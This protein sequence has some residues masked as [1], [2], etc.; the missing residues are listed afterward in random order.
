[1][2]KDKDL[3][4][5]MLE[6]PNLTLEDM[7]SV[8]HSAE[9]TRF[10]DKS[11]YENSQKVR[12]KFTDAEGNFKQ[13]EFNTWYDTAAKAYQ[14][15]TSKD[16]NIS[17]LNVAAFDESD[18]TVSPEKRTLNTK[19]IVSF[20]PNPDRL[21][22]SIY[23]VGKTSERERTQSELAQAEKILLNPVEA[24]A[25]PSKAKWGD[26]PNDSWWSN[27]FD[28]Q[29]LAQW[30]EDGT[31][32]D[33]VTGQ[34]VQHQKGELKLNDN[35]TYYYE[36]LDGR[37][38][39]GRQVL[40]K[41]NTITTDGSFW[42]QY[43]FFD[44]DDI[45][46]KSFVGSVA[47]NLA[48]VGSMFIPYV[49]WGVAGASVA[50]QL[51]GLTGTL[52][53][54][55]T[56]SDSPTF[57]AMEGW[58]KSLNRQTA[59]SEY[60]QQN[61]LCW[62]NF[63][64]LI[65]DTTAQL[66]EQRAIFKFAPAILG[67]GKYGI[68]SKAFGANTKAMGEEIADAARKE[69]TSNL[70]VKNILRAVGGE[71]PRASLARAGAA[72]DKIISNGIVDKAV[73][74]YLE[75]YNSLGEKIAR[76]YMVGITVG[77]TYGE[78]KEAGASDFE[79]TMLTLG[80]AAAENK[81]L[82]SELGKWIFPELKGQSATQRQIAK[83]MLE[84]DKELSA[85][86][87]ASTLDAA[88][89]KKTKAELIGKKIAGMGQDTKN[90]SENLG[91][92]DQ[93]TKTAWMKKWF[94]AGKDIFD[95]QQSVMKGTVGAMVSNALAEGTEEVTEELLKDFS[96]SCFNLVKAAQGD[97]DTRM[98]GFLGTWDWNEALK[99][100]GM[101]FF[102]GL[103]GGGINSAA[104]DY[105]QFRDIANMTSEQAMQ[106]LVW[107]ER[108][109]ETEKFWN[110]VSKMTL[111]DKQHTTERDEN[112]NYKLGDKDNNQDIEVKKAIR[113]QLDLIHNILTVNGANID[114]EG[115]IGQVMNSLPSLNGRD[116]LGDFR[117]NALATS[118]TA[119]RFLKEYNNLCKAIVLE[120]N[121][122]RNL[123]TQNVD[124]QKPTPDQ[125]Q[126]I[127]ESQE[128]LKILQDA[129]QKLLSGERT[130]EFYK[131]A[132]FETT[133]GVSESFIA[134]TEV[135]YMEMI[136]GKPYSLIT[137]EER[138]PL[139]DKYANWSKTERA[140]QIHQLS[141][142]F[143]DTTARTSKALQES[144]EMYDQMKNG[145]L[146]KLQKI[147]DLSS[148]KLSA[149]IQLAK[150]YYSE[151]PTEDIQNILSN[152]AKNDPA[153]KA[154]PLNVALDDSTGH[155]Y[156]TENPKTPGEVEFNFSDSNEQLALDGYLDKYRE[157]IENP[158][159]T[160]EEKVSN[161]INTYLDNIVSEIGNTAE[162]IIKS[163]YIHPEVKRAFLPVIEQ[164]FDELNGLSMDLA[165]DM[166]GT[167]DLA[168]ADQD[169][170]GEA[171]EK[172]QKALNDL[173]EKQD[174]LKTLNY[175]PISENLRNFA[176]GLGTNNTVLDLVEGAIKKE[177]S[178]QEA[179]D[180]IILDEDSE[181]QFDEAEK[182]LK[183]YRAS[184]IASGTDNADVDQIFGY[185]KALNELC[186][187]D[188]N[189]TPLAEIDQQIAGY[190]LQDVNLA[191][192]RLQAIKGISA[193]NQ[194][195]KLN[196]QNYTAANT[197][198]ILGNK[199]NT[200]ITNLLNEDDDDA[201]DVKNKW[202]QNGALDE[203]KLA[204]E[205]AELHKQ[206]TGKTVADRTLALNTAQK[207]QIERESH[208]IE[209]AIYNFFQ[210]NKDKLNDSA[211]ARADL[212]QFLKVAKFDYYKHN[213][214]IVTQSSEDIDDNAFTW[215]LASHAALKSSDFYNAYRKVISDDIAP[216]PTQEFGVYAS[217]AS[218]YNGDLFKAFGSAM[219]Q[220][221]YEDWKSKS[222]VV[223]NEDGSINKDAPSE[224]YNILKE[225]GIT[226]L[227]RTNED[228]D[229]V[230][231][232]D[233][234][235]NFNNI[236]FIE[237]IPGSGNI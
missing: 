78:A 54:M 97:K 104:T 199:L 21:S 25:D 230:L 46:E 72:Q 212:A 133:Y 138:K 1:M 203:L 137:E 201:R 51:V 3:F 229:A 62:E 32:V 152:W 10:L 236:L 106:Q 99:R 163:G 22:T 134:P 98:Q 130:A 117:A 155:V 131:D 63:I 132:M 136:T 92:V 227:P 79:A 59:K 121:N 139:R 111:G 197:K 112:G 168:I 102:G 195:N 88:G 224:K 49:G 169:R 140:E 142:M 13:D 200:L 36:S 116:I 100:Y 29:V 47:K 171:S 85:E 89:V 175:T 182:L 189:W 157:A 158:N 110:T 126:A 202:N 198:L 74:D 219:R 58:S 60:A 48:L 15:I 108:N 101:S 180:N 162:E 96:T 226:E 84:A 93:N 57:S 221:V 146:E 156:L 114:D 190:A 43:D 160:T 129:R 211:E 55:L 8:G 18:I 81:L 31:H 161:V 35:G 5:D 151:N 184:I 40:N 80:Y 135:Q 216:I 123:Q 143:Y 12:A 176:V 122:L 159:A 167:S 178:Y 144:H 206:L 187:N 26:S 148:Q 71:D 185:N 166:I 173:Q 30:D 217:I 113:Q 237:G 24:A 177:E 181:K 37:D 73:K 27:F 34:T 186:K 222:D 235:P 124:S 213:N 67:K 53:K 20:T 208:Q 69:S 14:Q 204:I 210:K 61:M 192:Q 64:D 147:T 11:A 77:D 105:S 209:D 19:P 38:T 172:V 75:D 44:S 9:S 65:G 150:G 193:L 16:N 125:E 33:P 170:L 94:N 95:T 7:V 232:C 214:D 215:W 128:N 154:N 119:G 153:N 127:K 207:E 76:A 196:I 6:N 90:I 91:S 83:K 223:Y 115:L 183:L 218:I 205:S 2:E 4:L 194:G 52:G 188:Q 39:Y 145:Q 179:V 228:I 23:R 233:F 87:L 191:L 82:N 231:G 225:R 70:D 149:I 164:T 174:A 220:Y 165:P 42:N 109:G 50:T 118:V 28:T 56:G 86:G 45:K 41:M 234:V 66:R 103:V 120:A 68:Q 17:L 107:M 141:T